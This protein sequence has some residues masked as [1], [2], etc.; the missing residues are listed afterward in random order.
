MSLYCH[1][2]DKHGKE[3][4]VFEWDTENYCGIRTPI[5]KR[6]MEVKD[7]VTL[8][9]PAIDASH[10]ILYIPFS[11]KHAIMQLSG[12]NYDYKGTH[13]H[14]DSDKF[15][16]K[17]L[18]ARNRWLRRHWKQHELR[19]DIERIVK[20]GNLLNELMALRRIKSVNKQLFVS[21]QT[22]D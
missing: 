19:K 17:K 4:C 1:V 14:I 12:S 15:V 2:Y 21:P 13:Y 6:D 3:Y 20:D 7:G 22:K 9:K 18:S 5:R 16:R 10:D 11:D 8:Q